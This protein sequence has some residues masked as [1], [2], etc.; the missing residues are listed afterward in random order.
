MK[1]LFVVLIIVAIITGI[2]LIFNKVLFK[3][4]LDLE[5]FGVD[6]PNILV[7]VDSQG[8]IFDAK[9]ICNIMKKFNLHPKNRLI[10]EGYY[11][12]INLQP[13]DFL[14]VNLD[15]TPLNEIPDNLVCKTRQAYDILKANFKNKNVIYTG[16][17]SE[18]RLKDGYL[19]DYNKLIHMAGKSPFKGTIELV[20]CWINH[21]ELP[22][23]TIKTYKGVTST[24]K[25]LL[26]GKSVQNII[27]ND[28]FLSDDK[29][30][31]LYNTYGI[32]ICSSYVEGW[33]HYIAEA[34]S[35]KAVVLYTDAH[36]MNETFIDGHDGIGINCDQRPTDYINKGLCPYY[37]VKENDIVNA[38][39]KVMA[40]SLDERRIIG[41]NARSRFL[42]NDNQFENNLINLIP[43][44]PV[45]PELGIL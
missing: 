40:L 28:A 38:V 29:I 8:L 45:P 19:M 17:T 7:P 21:P 4:E 5:L 32:H 6:C 39:K 22:V 12:M 30:D 41:N 23:L 34:K 10:M 3:K 14:F 44:E 9:I 1:K 25:K 27:V 33:G 2:G 18:D 11:G 24:V 36:P 20:N 31:E 26:D 35:C 42:E 13:D 15:C 37:Q 16:F 43:T